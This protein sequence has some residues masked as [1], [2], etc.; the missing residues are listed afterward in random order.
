ML[1]TLEAQYV[2]V[3]EVTQESQTQMLQPWD[4]LEYYGAGI[5]LTE[6]LAHL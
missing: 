5:P 2:F 6:L 3:N 1:G 4:Q